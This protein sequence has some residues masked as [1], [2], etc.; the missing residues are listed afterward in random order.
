[1]TSLPL[2][3]Q[4]Q[5]R[6]RVLSSSLQGRGVSA[7]H[8]A[9][10]NSFDL[11]ENLPTAWPTTPTIG[12]SAT[13][14]LPPP[15]G[16]AY[17]S[18]V[19]L[20]R[21]TASPQT[22]EFVL[23]EGTRQIEFRAQFFPDDEGTTVILTDITEERS[24]EAALASLL[25]EVSHR[26]KNLLAIV[27]SI[28]MQTG[29]HSKSTRDF[30]GKFIGR[31]HALSST[32]DL[33]TES[34]WRGTYLQSLVSAQLSRIGTF[35]LANVRITGENPILVPNAALHIGLAVHELAANAAI[36]G[37]LSNDRS[38]HIWVDAH[39][40]DAAKAGT[41]LVIEWQETGLSIPAGQPT[42]RFGTMMLERVVPL[43]VGGHARFSLTADRVAYR[44]EIPSDQ[45]RP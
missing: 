35:A 24:R 7:L 45:F 8:H 28:A 19:V 33:V 20:S 36:Y 43:S 23:P 3:G 18:Q 44:L 9:A 39:Y 12:A 2:D 31:L 26:S 13:N 16:E 38:G 29:K 22:L 5:M 4:L 27:Q 10:D 17:N 25:R 30:L 1:M 11:A 41:N 14:L 42:P 34:D 40:E 32:Q 37:A 21:T 15:V 6:L